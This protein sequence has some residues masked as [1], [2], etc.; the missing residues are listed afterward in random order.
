MRT[1]MPVAAPAK[2]IAP[3]GPSRTMC[4]RA[5][6]SSSIVFTWFPAGNS[7]QVCGYL[8]QTI[9]SNWAHANG[10]HPLEI[11]IRR[12]YA[13]YGHDNAFYGISMPR[14]RR[15][16]PTSTTAIRRRWEGLCMRARIP[17]APSGPRTPSKLR[18][19]IGQPTGRLRHLSERLPQIR[20][21]ERQPCKLLPLQATQFD[22]D[23]AS[24]QDAPARTLPAPGSKMSAIMMTTTPAHRRR[25]LRHEHSCLSFSLARGKLPNANPYLRDH[26]AGEHHTRNTHSAGLLMRDSAG[27]LTGSHQMPPLGPPAAITGA[28]HDPIGATACNW[29]SGVHHRRSIDRTASIRRPS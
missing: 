16:M 12:L 14:F 7:G 1:T 29:D 10:P 2:T 24:S 11:G 15:S 8:Q 13:G 6:S 26:A 4:S 5:G 9:A 19:T 25:L 21:E 23:P 17:A 20:G 18:Q 28:A 3:F 27:C 22:S